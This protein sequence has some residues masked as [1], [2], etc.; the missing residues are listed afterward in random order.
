MEADALSPRETNRNLLF[1]C[2]ESSALPSY[3]RKPNESNGT[4][5]LLCPIISI[6]GIGKRSQEECEQ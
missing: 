3:V 6:Q 4:H 2:F 5:S 1:L